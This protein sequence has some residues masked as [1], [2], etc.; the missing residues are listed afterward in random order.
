MMVAERKRVD[1][2][3][4]KNQHARMR[5]PPVPPNG[6]RKVRTR[7]TTTCIVVRLAERSVKTD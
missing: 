3:I 1:R 5:P 2:L 6:V 7:N 4:A